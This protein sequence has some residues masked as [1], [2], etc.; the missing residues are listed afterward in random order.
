[1]ISTVISWLRCAH[2]LGGGG[3]T[4]RMEPCAY[5]GAFDPRQYL[6]DETPDRY[7]L[8]WMLT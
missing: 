6:T 7:G 3:L 2:A 5:L 8:A 4:V 1:M